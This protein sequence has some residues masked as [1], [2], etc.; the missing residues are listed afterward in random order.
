MNIAHRFDVD[1]M[2]TAGEPVRI[3]RADDLLLVQDDVLAYRRLLRDSHDHIRQALMLEPRGHADMYG[4]LIFENLKDADLGAVFIHNSGY[5]TMCGHATIA[6]GRWLYEQDPEKEHQSHYAK[7]FRIQCPCGPVEAHVSATEEGSVTTSFDS[8]G[9]FAE[10]LDE[11]ANIP[12]LGDV[13]YDIGYGGAYY[14]ILPASSLGLD[15]HETPV[16]KLREVAVMIT[17]HLRKTR[18]IKHPDE[19]DLSFLYGTI[20]TDDRDAGHASG[21]TANLCVFAQGQIDR[22]PTGSGVCAR[23]AVDQAKGLIS[24]GRSVRFSGLSGQP[25]SAEIM[26]ADTAQIKVR[27]TGQSFFYG[28]SRLFVEAGDPLGNGLRIPHSLSALKT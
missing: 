3:L 5:S 19:A 7:N 15:F 17:D 25:F 14:A 2:H 6:L 13:R 22:S 21:H 23:L 1:D 4:A 8:V 24:P 18:P 9:C 27:V 28:Q 11:Y 10:G 16:A 26:H 20:L 12:G